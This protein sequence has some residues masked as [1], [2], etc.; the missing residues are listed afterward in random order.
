MCAGHVKEYELVALQLINESRKLNN[1]INGSR[2]F[3]NQPN[4]TQI[5]K[6]KTNKHANKHKHNQYK[7]KDVSNLINIQIYENGPNRPN[8]QVHM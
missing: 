6:R 7:L 5:N 3:N 4:N 8:R 2:E 1:K